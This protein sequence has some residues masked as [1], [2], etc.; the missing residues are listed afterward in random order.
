MKYYWILAFPWIINLQLTR[1]NRTQSLWE[2]LCISHL[3]YTYKQEFLEIKLAPA[4]GILSTFPVFIGYCRVFETCRDIHILIPVE[5]RYRLWPTPEH[6]VDDDRPH[7]TV[8]TT[9]DHTTPC[10]RRPTP[11]HRADDDRPHAQHRADDCPLTW[12]ELRLDYFKIWLIQ[13]LLYYDSSTLRIYTCGK[14]NL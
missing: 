3:E 7:N 6:R 8:Q 13:I 5:L 1:M 11:Q 9:T 2:N 4:R 10:R 12:R 14:V